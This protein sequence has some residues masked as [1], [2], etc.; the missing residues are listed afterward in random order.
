[1]RV[2]NVSIIRE[3]LDCGCG[4]DLFV[5]EADAKQTHVVI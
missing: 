1:M 4:S 5:S 3:G 2:I